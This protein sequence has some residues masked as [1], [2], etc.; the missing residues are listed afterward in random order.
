MSTARTSVEHDHG[1]Y[2][3]LGDNSTPDR[4]AS[5]DRDEHDAS[6][7]GDGDSGSSSDEDSG[8]KRL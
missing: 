5:A 8:S 2:E 7:S 3:V 1:S 6:R 4:S